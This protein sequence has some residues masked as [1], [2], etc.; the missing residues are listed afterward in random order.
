MTTAP[1]DPTTRAESEAATPATPAADSPA[2]M[3]PREIITALSGLMMGMLVAILSST[4]VSTSLPRIIADLGGGQSSYTWVVTATLLAMTVSTPVWGKLADIFDRKLLLQLSLGLFT[5][6]SVLAAFSQSAGQLIACRGVQGL[7]VGGLMSLAIIVISDIISP[8]ERGKYMG[9]L[10]G[11]MSIGTIGGPLLGGLVTDAIGWRANFFL[12]VPLSLGALLVIQKTLHL[13]KRA[14]TGDVRLDYLGAFLVTAAVSTLLIWVTLAGSSFDWASVTSYVMVGGSILAA[15]LFVLVERK[16]H[17]PLLPMWL[18]RNRTVV[19]T[20]IASIAVGV[21]MFGTTVFLSQYMQLARGETPTTSGLL[22]LP[23]VLGSVVSSIVIGQLISRTG[24]WKRYM[25]TGT[26]F[27]TVGLALMG[28]IHY[29]TPFWHLVIFM[30]IVGIGIGA[31]MQNLMLVTQNVLPV[32]EMGAG[33]S[34]V[35]FFRSLGGAVGVSAMGA[36]LGSQ[37]S[38]RITDGLLSLGVPASAMGS[39]GSGQIPD[40]SELPGPVRLV[41][42]QSYGE[43]V[44]HVFLAA[45]PLAIVAFIAVA[46]LPNLPLGTKTGIEQMAEERALAEGATEPEPE[47]G[48]AA[49]GSE[50]A[51]AVDDPHEPGAHKAESVGTHRR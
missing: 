24:V 27:L 38:S 22:T 1:P 37:A 51:A 7:G 11:V 14:R 42:E 44:A 40:L 26:L 32:T 19:L 6:G 13:P 46:L 10:G 34:S 49:R 17:S 33:S 25:V 12:V 20:I 31:V 2:P 18:F 43:A 35:T 8:R 4:V 47:T 5:I 48:P 50:T 16:A 36:L 15:V 23:M 39:G 29:D 3:T 30:A 45:V 28:T 41:V 21:A 9:V